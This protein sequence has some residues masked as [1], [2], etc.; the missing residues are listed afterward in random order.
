LRS[1]NSLLSDTGAQRVAIPTGT[2]Q[3]GVYVV[4]VILPDGS[5]LTGQLFVL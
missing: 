3:A 4:Q 2:L 5:V 1:S